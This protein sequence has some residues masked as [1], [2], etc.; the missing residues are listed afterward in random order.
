[1]ACSY[2]FDGDHGASPPSAS[3][4]A[5]AAVF[6]RELLRVPGHVAGSIEGPDRHEVGP[7]V[8]RVAVAAEV[9]VGGHHVGLVSA[10]EPHQPPDRLVQVRLPEAARVVVAGPAHHV[11]VVVAEVLPLGHAEVGHGP[12]EFAG[13]D[14]A[15][16][17]MVLG[18][19][20]LRHDDLALLATRA[21]DEDHP[22]A[23]LDGLD[24]GAARADRLVVRMGVDGHQRRA[25]RDGL[26]RR[27]VSAWA[28]GCVASG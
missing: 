4:E 22:V 20:H 13:P 11:G 10:H 2:S 21:G 18:C 24:H 26:G 25:M 3:A 12:L 1:M 8:V 27:G 15:Q 19:V 16:P 6:G 28:S 9:V 17:S 23:G 14:L 7:D 5:G